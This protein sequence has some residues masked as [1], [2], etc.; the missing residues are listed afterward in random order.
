MYNLICRFPLLCLYYVRFTANSEMKLLLMPSVLF[1]GHML[2]HVNIGLTVKQCAHQIPS[3]TLEANI[4]PI[5]RTV[6]RVRLIVTPDFHWND[7]V[8]ASPY[9][10][11]AVFAFLFICYIECSKSKLKSTWEC[12]Y[13]NFSVVV[14]L[15]DI[16]QY[17][18]HPKIDALVKHWF[19]IYRLNEWFEWKEIHACLCLDSLTFL[20]FKRTGFGYVI[21]IPLPQDSIKEHRGHV[22]VFK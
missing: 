15:S 16:C 18:Q 6:L 20:S 13:A 5:T 22:K 17:S 1:P 14:S 21:K 4:Q 9:A 7:Q 10:Y 8:N 12:C 2:H 11:T 3:I 19:D